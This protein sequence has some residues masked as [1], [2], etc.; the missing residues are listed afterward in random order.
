MNVR[1]DRRWVQHGTAPFVLSKVRFFHVLDL[2]A[3]QVRIK[4]PK[5]R[6]RLWLFQHILDL[7]KAEFLG[8]SDVRK[9]CLH[10]PECDGALLVHC[11]P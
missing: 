5:L 9:D 11:V 6:R 7:V 4:S 2:D 3:G 8:L 10:E 1:V